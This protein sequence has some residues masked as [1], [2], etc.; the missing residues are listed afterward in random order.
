VAGFS[1]AGYFRKPTNYTEF[2]R[3]GPMVKA[4]LEQPPKSDRQR[5]S[6]F[7]LVR[8]LTHNVMVKV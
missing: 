1:I 6:L 3:L 2:M 8:P 4:L 7:H 5:A